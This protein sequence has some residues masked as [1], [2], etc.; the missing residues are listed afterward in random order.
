MTKNKSETQRR[1]AANFQCG[2]DP[3]QDAVIA[4]IDSLPVSEK[5]SI[6]NSV[7]KYHITE[8]L[9]DYIKKTSKTK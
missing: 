8:A 1:I 3:R 4:W 9:L 5:G 7:V 2:K 6:K